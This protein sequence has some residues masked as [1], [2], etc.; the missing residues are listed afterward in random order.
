[1][2]IKGIVEPS[3]FLMDSKTFSVPP[4]IAAI[5]TRLSV[6]KLAPQDLTVTLLGAHGRSLPKLW[7]GGLRFL[8]QGFGFSNAGA[9]I[10]LIRLADRGLLER[11]RDAHDGRRVHYTLT[12]RMLQI[13]KEGDRRLDSQKNSVENVPEWTVVWHWIP[14]TQRRER[15][16]LAR[17]LRF[18][19]FGPIREATWISPH[20]RERSVAGVIAN[21]GVEQHAHVMLGRPAGTDGFAG[22]IDQAWDVD[23]LCER[24]SNFVSVFG[25]YKEKRSGLEDPEAFMVRIQLVHGFRRFLE[26]D[27]GLPDSTLKNPEARSEAVS[28]FH[29]LYEDLKE[30]AHRH[31][32]HHV[33]A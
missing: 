7:S 12:P 17:R 31:F 22:L 4:S 2:D 10:A 30:P 11:S 23:A 15:T 27:P 6:E 21:L 14:D 9:R 25:D 19:G 33:D 1:M 13:L 24:Y 16:R 29:E 5:D 32:A 28:L 20:D 18:L 8:L 3:S 26:L